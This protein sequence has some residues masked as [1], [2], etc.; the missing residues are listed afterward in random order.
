MFSDDV[1]S[2]VP[3]DALVG[4]ACR[5]SELASER[6]ETIRSWSDQELFKVIA[7]VMLKS[8]TL[9]M[10]ESLLTLVLTL[11]LFQLV[12]SIVVCMSVLRQEFNLFSLHEEEH[13]M[14]TF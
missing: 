3:L 7:E 12:N 9:R 11:V 1:V 5:H 6:P 2:V 14:P 4:T 8:K 13:D 10:Y